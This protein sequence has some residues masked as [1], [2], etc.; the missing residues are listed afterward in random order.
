MLSLNVP[1]SVVGVVLSDPPPP[2]QAVSKVADTMRADRGRTLKMFFMGYY[3][4]LGLNKLPENATPHIE[5]SSV[6][7]RYFCYK[8]ELGFVMLMS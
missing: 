7:D 3:L 4:I 6:Q 8:V 1:V 5:L 2:P